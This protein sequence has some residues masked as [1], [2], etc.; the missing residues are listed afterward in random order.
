MDQQLR[1]LAKLMFESN[2][3][4]EMFLISS[5]NQFWIPDGT[6]AAQSHQADLNRPKEENTQL[7]RINREMAFA[8]EVILD[9]AIP[10]VN[11]TKEVI[12][13]YL[14]SKGVDATTK[15]KKDDLL[16]KLALIKPDEA[17]PDAN[18]MDEVIVEYLMSHGV[19]AE[20]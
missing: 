8:Q 2:P 5:D 11:S 7:M 20:N 13:A 14:M 19:A 6:N 1:E 15:E 16:E 4:V 3:T 17:V 12:V 10:D 18:S 9:E